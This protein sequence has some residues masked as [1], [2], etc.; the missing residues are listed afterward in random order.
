MCQR[1]DDN[2]KEKNV[3]KK[4]FLFFSPSIRSLPEDLP[5]FFFSFKKLF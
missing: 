3:K 2:V 4:N 1:K 5:Y